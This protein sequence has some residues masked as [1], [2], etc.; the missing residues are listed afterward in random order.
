[1]I[2]IRLVAEILGYLV[3]TAIVAVAGTLVALQLVVAV[4]TAKDERRAYREQ[5]EST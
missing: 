2:A 5:E 4:A 1:M 3:M